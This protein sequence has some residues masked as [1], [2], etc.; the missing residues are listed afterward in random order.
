MKK[1]LLTLTAITCIT[2]ASFAQFTAG[3]KAGINFASLSGDA[4]EDYDGRTVFHAGLYGNYSLSEKLSIQ[5]E[6]LYNSVGAKYED[7]YTDPD[8][9]D[10]DYKETIKLDYLSV[11][12]MLDYKLTDQFSLQVG[13]Q[14]GFLLSAKYEAEVEYDGDSESYNEDIK[15]EMK[16]TDFGLNFGAAY[17]FVKLNVTFRYSLGLSNAADYDE[18]DLKNNNIQISLGYKLFGE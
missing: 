16:G 18:G 17:S 4:A 9:G 2:V 13:P 6:L 12:V 5:P 8:F 15:D 3:V 1:V 7:S 11:P 14:I 10:V